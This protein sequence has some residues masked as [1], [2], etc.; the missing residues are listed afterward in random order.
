[1]YWGQYAAPGSKDAASVNSH[2]R[3]GP[4]EDHGIKE[5][6]RLAPGRRGR[7]KKILHALAFCTVVLPGGCRQASCS[8]ED[9]ATGDLDDS[10]PKRLCK[11]DA[12]E[13]SPQVIN[14]YAVKDIDA[15]V[16]AV[17]GGTSVDDPGT[18]VALRVTD[19]D[20]Q[21][22]SL[23]HVDVFEC[24]DV[25]AALETDV[26]DVSLVP[27]ANTSAQ[28]HCVAVSA[29]RLDCLTNYEGRASF[30]LKLLRSTTA[31]I[32]AGKAAEQASNR[33]GFGIQLVNRGS[34]GSGGATSRTNIGEGG[35]T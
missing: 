30:S 12:I 21:P 17:G 10:S 34:G 3:E 7:W 35:A 13:F 20:D 31:A 5:K 9:T 24:T 18:S 23:I 1:L 2:E 32:C 29:T 26:L 27:S 19:G 28:G 15:A 6:A 22:R 16:A 33:D 11:K 8:E 14:T 4:L 25:F